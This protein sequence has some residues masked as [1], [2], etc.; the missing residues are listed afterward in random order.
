MKEALY[1]EP[2]EEVGEGENP[3]DQCFEDLEG[4]IEDAEEFCQM[5]P[6]ERK[7]TKKADPLFEECDE[8]EDEEACNGDVEEWLEEEIR[9]CGLPK[10]HKKAEKKA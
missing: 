1:C 5:S 3:Y 8:A 2:E 4:E 9:I 7:A 10:C 6:C